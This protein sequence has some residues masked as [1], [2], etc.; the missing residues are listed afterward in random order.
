MIAGKNDSYFTVEEFAAM[1]NRS[2]RTIQNWISLHRLK[3]RYLFG[4]PMIP[5]SSIENII[6]EDAPPHAKEGRL[7]LRLM[8]EG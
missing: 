5:L 8:N 6:A 3:P 4:I 2:P 1:I 7:A